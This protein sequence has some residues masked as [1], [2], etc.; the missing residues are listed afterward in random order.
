MLVWD[1][2]CP[3]TLAPSHSTL[4]VREAGAV[5][6]DAEYKKTLKY[7]HFNSSHCFVL[8]AV[9]TLGVFGKAARHFFKEVAQCVKL[10]ADDSLAHQYL[11]ERISMDVQ[12]GNAAGVLG[13]TGV[14][15]VG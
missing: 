2:T 12:R 11:V 6:A 1:A 14:R 13:C 3:D 10:A 4:A 7:M 15:G 9:E 5:A 8:V